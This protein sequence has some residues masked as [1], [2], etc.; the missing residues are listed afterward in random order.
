M[1]ITYPLSLPAT[2]SVSEITLNAINAVAYSRSPFT[3]TGQAHAYAGEMWSA[4]I[5]LK[6][7]READAEKWSAWLTALRGQFG[8]FLLGNPFRNSPRGTAT[9]ATITGS[10]G[11]RSVTVAKTGTLLAGDY[12]QLGT[13]TQARLYKVLEDSSGSGTLEIWPALRASASGVA[14]DLT[15]PVGAF[16]LSSNEASWSV[17]NL[18][19][20]GITF[21]AVEA[22]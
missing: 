21:G 2:N 9:A 3:F 1:A 20:Y 14:A 12:F 19:V 17:N 16:R 10:A 5:T 15:S 18:A 4:D 6:A 7:M 11:A 13:T 22:I 8:T